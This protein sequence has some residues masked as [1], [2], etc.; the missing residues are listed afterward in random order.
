MDTEQPTI[1]QPPLPIR[2]G[3]FDTSIDTKRRLV[4]AADI[5]SGMDPNR[6]GSSFFSFIGSN[7]K[8]WLYPRN[9]YSQLISRGKVGL[10]P[11]PRH[12]EFYYA[13]V[14][15]SYDLAWDKQGRVIVPQR[16][17]EWAKIELPAE[18]TLVG[19]VDHYELW[20]RTEWEAHLKELRP[21]WS[22]IMDRARDDGLIGNG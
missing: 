1:S 7:E 6:D 3:S 10:T 20:L 16:L 9:A 22:A 11:D 12:L 18:V 2:F 17:V 19:T 8:I 21:R 15:T 5:R 13:V 4:L 14:G